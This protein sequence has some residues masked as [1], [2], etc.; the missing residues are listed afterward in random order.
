MPDIGRLDTSG[1]LQLL[2]RAGRFLKIAGR[3][4]NLA[5]VEHALRQLPGVRDAAV[6]PH[7]ERADA[8]AAVVAGDVSS[9]VLRDLLRERLASW[10]IPRKWIVLPEFPL[11]PRGKPDLR[12]VRELLRA[13]PTRTQDVS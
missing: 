6:A 12:K 8:L 1:E 4:L 2:G 3:R 9:N 11:T 10:K 7:P 5:E 13:Q